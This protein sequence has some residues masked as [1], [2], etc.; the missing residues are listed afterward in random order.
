[1][2]PLKYIAPIGLVLITLQTHS[3]QKQLSIGDK[4]PLLTLPNTIN[5]KS[6][7]LNF[8]DYKGKS[9]IL[10]FWNHRCVPCLAAFPHLDSLQQQFDNDIQLILVNKESKDSTINF[11]ARRKKIKM[12]SLPM[13]TG[14]TLLSSMFPSEGYPYHVWI[15]RNG[16][17]SYFSG[18]YNTTAK[19]ISDFLEGSKLELK[20]PTLRKRNDNP[21]MNTTMQKGLIYYSAI[22]RCSNELDIGN[23]MGEI[24]NEDKAVKLSVNCS[25]VLDLYKLAFEEKGKYNFAAQYS[26]DLQVSDKYSYTSPPD[27]N[28]MDDW[29]DNHAFNYQLIVPVAMAN[30]RFKIM[31]QDL[32]RF[33]DLDAKI[34]IRKVKSLVLKNTIPTS[35]S[36]RRVLINGDSAFHFINQPL[37][38]LINFLEGW[39]AYEYP[40]INELNETIL[41]NAIVKASSVTPLNV[42]SLMQDLHFSGLELCLEVRDMPVLCLSQK[43]NQ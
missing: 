37:G 39:I 27:N 1:M 5:N 8:A 9:I 16:T 20:D 21:A 33:F 17:I 43:K 38:D 34:E 7:H 6:G 42:S 24:I 2:N 10:D 28:K 41:I 14:D 12:P 19:H 31:Q 36:T 18:G 3:Q 13:I 26:L 32:Q 40:F 11:F 25:S 4:L 15:D 30:N 23:A 35:S 22:S 29:L